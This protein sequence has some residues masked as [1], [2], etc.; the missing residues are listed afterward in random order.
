MVSKKKFNIIVVIMFFCII[1]SSCGTVGNKDLLGSQS[2]A[3]KYTLHIGLNDKN[4]YK[5]QISDEKAFQI[6]TNTS[7]KYVNGF[8]IYRCQGLYKDKKSK[9]TKENSLVLEIYG[10][11]EKEIKSIMDELL[12]SLNQ[13]SILVEKGDVTYEFYSKKGD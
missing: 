6:V 10:A 5:Q 4:T 12:V 9:I 3:T 1:L 8:T 2:K 7:L 11:N 13:E